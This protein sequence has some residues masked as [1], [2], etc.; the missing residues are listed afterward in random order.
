MI[1]HFSLYSQQ[2]R[3]QQIRELAQRHLQM[4]AEGYDQM[5]GYT[6]DYNAAEGGAQMAGMQAVD[7][8]DIVYGLD[9]PSTVAPQ[10][11]GGLDDRQILSAMLVCH[12]NS[13]KNHMAGS[14]EI[15][16]PN[17]RQMAINGA[18][19]CSNMAYEIFL[20]MNRD[21]LYQVPTMHDHTA[22]TM[23]HTYQP[24]NYPTEQRF[25]Q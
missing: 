17:I 13:A 6:H 25:D 15:A 20:V 8:R 10:T 16:D 14:L 2:A 1:A 21:G 11:G 3:T 19:S 22:K 9:N 5:V 12:K 23:L 18:V 24:M 7:P 4:V